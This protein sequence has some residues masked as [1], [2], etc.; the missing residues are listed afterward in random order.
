MTSPC[1]KCE[2]RQVGCHSTCQEYKAFKRIS[3]ERR[4]QLNSERAKVYDS[5][6]RLIDT[7]IKRKY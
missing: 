2:E 3:D 5:T 4:E 6:S 1:L 7:I